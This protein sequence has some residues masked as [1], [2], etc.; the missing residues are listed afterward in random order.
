MRDNLSIQCEL[1]WFM[2]P[3]LVTF[4]QKEVTHLL[5]SHS[6]RWVYAMSVKNS[7]QKMLREQREL[8]MF[9]L[10]FLPCDQHWLCEASDLLSDP[11]SASLSYF[12]LYWY[13]EPVLVTVCCG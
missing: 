4:M 6:G 5:S 11:S 10:P 3:V 1:Q 13:V 9:F 2:L 7:S 8:E 12:S